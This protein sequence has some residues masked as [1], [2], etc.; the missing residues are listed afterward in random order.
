[1]DDDVEDLTDISEEDFLM[2]EKAV[3]E[4]PSLANIKEMVLDTVDAYKMTAKEGLEVSLACQAKK[5]IR[6]KASN[7]FSGIIEP[8]VS[9]DCDMDCHSNYGLL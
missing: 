2:M 6:S 3:V 1:M 5:N 9:I 7:V 8:L 4:S